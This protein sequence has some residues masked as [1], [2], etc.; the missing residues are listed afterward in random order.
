MA[1]GSSAFCVCL[2]G[3]TGVIVRVFFF[4][5][6][7][8]KETDLFFTPSHD[9]IFRPR[10]RR[11]RL[12]RPRP[13]GPTHPR[14]DDPHARA[15]GRHLDQVRR[16]HRP[17]RRAAALFFSRLA[18]LPWMPRPTSFADHSVVPADT[19]RPSRLSSRSSTI[20][21]CLAHQIDRELCSPDN[22]IPLSMP[23]MGNSM[24]AL[25]LCTS[26][27]ALISNA[28]SATSA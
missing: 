16:S 9:G 2:R 26:D 13:A 3:R 1:E 22:F 21:S 19:A 28:S 14:P 15:R 27:G 10:R 17:R 4:L 11:R 23:A 24:P 18:P 7:V 6:D 12:H 5:N 20:S 25:H 8:S